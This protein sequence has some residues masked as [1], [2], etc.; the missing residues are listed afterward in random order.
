MRETAT[1]LSENYEK[2]QKKIHEEIIDELIDDLYAT[3]ESVFDRYE[4]NIDAELLNIPAIRETIEGYLSKVL[5]IPLENKE[6]EVEGDDVIKVDFTR[7][8]K[9]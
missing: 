8:R 3:L 5:K 2:C 9:R 1:V 6:R 4:G 7:P